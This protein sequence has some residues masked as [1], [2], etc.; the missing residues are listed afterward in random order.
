MSFVVAVP[1]ALGTT[2]TD[3]AGIGATLSA[4]NASAATQTTAVLAAAEDVVSA[5]IASLFSAHGQDFQSLSAQAAAFHDQFVQALTAGSGACAAA[6]TA[7]ASPLQSLVDAIN[8]SVQAATGR[9]LVGNG[10][11]GAPGTGAAGGPGGW[12]LG[13][14]GAGG[15]GVAG[16]GGHGGAGGNAGLYGAGGAG[17]PAAPC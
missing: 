4:A 5:S 8:A 14:G 2:A 16:A 13:N 17:G 1:D 10:A 12:L 7:N 3:L 6:E 11:N 15:S 9:P